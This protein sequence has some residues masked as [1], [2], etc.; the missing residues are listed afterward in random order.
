MGSCSTDSETDGSS[1][2]EAPSQPEGRP[3]FPRPSSAPPWIPEV[4]GRGE[5]GARDPWPPPRPGLGAGPG[6]GAPPPFHRPSRGPDRGLARRVGGGEGAPTAVI[7][8][9]G[10]GSRARHPSR[11]RPRPRRSTEPQ[12]PRWGGT[13]E[14]TRPRSR[15]G[16]AAARPMPR[17]GL[18]R[19]RGGLAVDGVERRW[20]GRGGGSAGGEAAPTPR[21]FGGQG[22]GPSPRAGA[23]LPRGVR[24]GTGA[25]GVSG[26]PGGKSSRRGAVEGAYGPFD[27]PSPCPRGP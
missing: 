21:R 22:G 19:S 13:P 9:S 8:R 6:G 3:K 17:R 25:R 24:A 14:A 20:P 18:S 26:P 5:A 2:C 16:A 10:A 15:W 23:G 4:R 12:P 27:P 1:W 11:V 7:H